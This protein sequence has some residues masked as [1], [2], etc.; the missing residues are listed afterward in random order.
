MT[1]CVIIER[2]TRRIVSRT[3]LGEH[4][5]KLVGNVYAAHARTSTIIAVYIRV[6]EVKFSMLRYRVASQ[7]VVSRSAP[8]LLP[9][10]NKHRNI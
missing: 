6:S 9:E 3:D 2:T 4:V 7:T 10:Y 8:T 1:P 5:G